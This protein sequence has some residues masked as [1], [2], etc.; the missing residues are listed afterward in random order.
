M[1]HLNTALPRRELFVMDM[2]TQK[3]YHRQR[4][5]KYFTKHGA[6]KTAIRYK[7]SRKTVYKWVKRYDGTIESLKDKGH[8]PNKHLKQHTPEELAL[9]K[10]YIIDFSSVPSPKKQHTI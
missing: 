3:A 10:R 1:N 8:R 4:M 6:I 9:I 5:V 2:I 7:T